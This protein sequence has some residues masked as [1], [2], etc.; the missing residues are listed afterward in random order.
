MGMARRDLLKAAGAAVAGLPLGGIDGEALGGQARRAWAASLPAI[1]A[2]DVPD[3]VVLNARIHTLDD[4]GRTVEALAIKNGR[5]LAVGD[6]ATIRG[7][8]GPGTAQYDLARQLPAQ[9]RCSTVP[10]RLPTPE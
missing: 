6:T 2:G 9:R 5:V 8:A 7:L 10:D 1:Q 3:A 4:Q